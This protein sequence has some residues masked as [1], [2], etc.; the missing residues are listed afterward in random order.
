MEISALLSLCIIVFVMI[1]AAIVKFAW[2]YTIS[3]MFGTLPITYTQSFVLIVLASILF[4][5]NCVCSP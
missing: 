3:Q 2:N 5:G 1:Q 4:R